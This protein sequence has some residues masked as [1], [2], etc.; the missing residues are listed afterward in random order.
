MPEVSFQPCSRK[1]EF[2]CEIEASI[3]QVWKTK[4]EW[5]KVGQLSKFE[6][7][8]WSPK[9]IL[10]YIPLHKIIH[11]YWTNTPTWLSRETSSCP[12]ALHSP[13]PWSLWHFPL[14]SCKQTF[15]YLRKCPP[16]ESRWITRVG[17]HQDYF[18]SFDRLGV[19]DKF[20]LSLNAGLLRRH[21]QSSLHSR[22]RHT[23]CIGT[24]QRT[25]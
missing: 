18:P 25:F 23:S 7:R 3:I 19:F 20:N 11:F 10:I 5:G 4:S 14:F 16:T 21:N 17:L 1:H 13:C 15:G 8:L 6:C 2:L 24:S 9:V 22:N 12:H